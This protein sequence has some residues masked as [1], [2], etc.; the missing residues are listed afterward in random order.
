MRRAA[1]LAL[2]AIVALPFAAAPVTLAR[3]TA[4]PTSTATFG[5]ATL[6]A[7]TSLAGTNGTIA[8]LTW[9]PSTTSG[10][11][12]YN[13]LRSATSGS[14]YAPV[15]AVTPV[16]ATTTTDAPANGTWYYVLQTYFQGWT[17]ANSNQASVLV[18][19]AVSTG[20]KGCV[21]TAAVTTASGDN[22]GYEGNPTRACAGPDGSVATDAN[23]GTGTTS[24]CAGATKDR[25][26]FY[27][28]AFA[29]PGGVTSIDGI[30]V[31]ADVGLNNTTG[32]STLCV[33]LSWDGGTNWTAAK[34]NPVTATA[35][36]T[37]TFGAAGD[38]WGH[39]PWTTTELN[40]TL[41]RVRVTDSA[42]TTTKTFRLD[43]LGVQVTYTP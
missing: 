10:A 17:S 19:P 29:L 36:T 31:R 2:A 22:N 13:V 11:T 34:S 9:V 26:L 42:T 23:T 27:G 39:S 14:G 41:F 8:T 15:K 6:A 18:G 38:A 16:S 24:T 30:T 40:T 25:H 5:T 43:Y 28:Y 37:Y 1:V 33:E 4:S 12:G 32:T 35:V 7:P 20:Y 21:T 3:L